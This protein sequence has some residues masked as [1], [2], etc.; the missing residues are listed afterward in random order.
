MKRLL[1]VLLLAPAFLVVVSCGRKAETDSAAAAEEQNKEKF[2]KANITDDTDF[3]VEAADGGRL[4]VELGRLAIAQGRSEE[5]KQLG[6]QMVDD[7]SKANQ[8]LG[9]IASEKNIT[10]PEDLGEKNRKTYDDLAKKTGADFDKE[11]ARLMVSD[12]KHDLEEFKKEADKGNDPDIK[13]WAAGKV[14]VLE[15]HLAMAESTHKA[16]KESK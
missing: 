2:E 4:E 6:Q 9:A 7:H 5:V 8:E 16:I 3:A 1:Y 15:H 14:P 12:H 10:L 13:N 11:Y